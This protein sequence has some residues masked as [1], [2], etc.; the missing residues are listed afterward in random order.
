MEYD[1][2]REKSATDLWELCEKENIFPSYLAE[3]IAMTV[4][5]RKKLVGIVAQ[6]Y[7]EQSMPDEADDFVAVIQAQ[8]CL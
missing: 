3:F 7:R 4:I 5:H 6:L 2:E 1:V 8:V